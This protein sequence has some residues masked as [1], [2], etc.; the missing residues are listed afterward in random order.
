MDLDVGYQPSQRAYNWDLLEILGMSM[1][2]FSKGR[3]VGP[4][5]GHCQYGH[6]RTQRTK[7][8]EEVFGRIFFKGLVVEDLDFRISWGSSLLSRSGFFRIQIY[9]SSSTMGKCNT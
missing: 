3:T 7:S 6:V 4:C 8:C 5:R 9:L 1:R 2:T